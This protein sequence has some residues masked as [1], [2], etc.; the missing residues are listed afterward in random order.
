MAVR[1]GFSAKLFNE[2]LRNYCMGDHSWVDISKPG[3]E[4]FCYTLFS[5]GD[6]SRLITWSR[7]NVRVYSL[8]P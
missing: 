3:S 5:Y 8:L 4:P 6:D 7:G 2:S 1:S